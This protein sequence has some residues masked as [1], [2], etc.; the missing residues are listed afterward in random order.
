MW[1]LSWSWHHVIHHVYPDWVCYFAASHL[2]KSRSKLGVKLLMNCSTPN[3]S[4]EGSDYGSED[5]AKV[6]PDWQYSCRRILIISQKV[7]GTTTWRYNTKAL[8]PEKPCDV[9]WHHLMHQQDILSSFLM[10]WNHYFFI[11]SCVIWRL[12]AW[13]HNTP[14]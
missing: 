8:F 2:N 3:L 5:S 7:E 6:D 14:K 12:Y 1:I 13:T 10:H 4:P 11:F 9:I